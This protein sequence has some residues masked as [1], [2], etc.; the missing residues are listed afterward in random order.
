[1]FAVM[2]KFLFIAV[3]LFCPFDRSKV[4]PCTALSKDSKA[5]LQVP[6]FFRKFRK[7]QTQYS[8]YQHF[9]KNDVPAKTA[10]IA[11]F[12]VEIRLL[13]GPFLGKKAGKKALKN[14][15]GFVVTNP[16]GWNGRLCD[17]RRRCGQASLPDRD[18][19]TLCIFRSRPATVMSQS[20]S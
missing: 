3:V 10:C 2:S 9:T 13:E 16:G 7:K 11:R 12:G 15:P 18:A 20:V 5:P 17:S 8:L 6:Q 14:P 1:M 4:S 19:L